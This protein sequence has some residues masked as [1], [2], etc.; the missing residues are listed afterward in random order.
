MPPL[1]I[2]TGNPLLRERAFRE[3][4]I[5][6]VTALLN[7]EDAIRTLH[8]TLDGDI[9]ASGVAVDGDSGISVRAWRGRAWR[10]R[11]GRDWQAG[12][13]K[14]RRIGFVRRARANDDR[15]K[16]D[17]SLQSRALPAPPVMQ[18]QGHP[19]ADR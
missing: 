11:A 9:A 5:P 12:A 1:W 2:S 6:F 8:K 10:R 7:G 19:P 13:G 17:G 3:G 15:A 18:A 4:H 16:I 14:A